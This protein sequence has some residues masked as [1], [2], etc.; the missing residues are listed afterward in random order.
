MLG[1]RKSTEIRE[2][3]FSQH[4]FNWMIKSL[5]YFCYLFK[6]PIFELI[7]SV[8]FL[9]YVSSISF[10]SFSCFRF[11]LLF[12]FQIKMRCTFLSL[13]LPLFLCRY[14]KLKFSSK[15][16]FHCIPYVLVCCVFHLHSL[17]YFKVLP[18]F[19]FGFLTLWLFLII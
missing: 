13:S 14:L 4:Y 12:S 3:N 2:N 8:L 11:S 16:W 18:D 15:H 19:S 17:V 1:G 5:P 7:F 6:E 10:I 9:F